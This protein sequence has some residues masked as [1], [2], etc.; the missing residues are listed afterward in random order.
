MNIRRSFG[1]VRSRVTALATVLV[2]VALCVAAVVIVLVSRNLMLSTADRGTSQRATE[3]ATTIQAEGLV[4][5]D[6]ALLDTDQYVD[7]IQIIGP[8]GEVIR[9]S[10]SGTVCPLGAPVRPSTETVEPDRTV[11]KSSGDFRTTFVGVVAPDGSMLTV[12]VGAAEAPLKR[13]VLVVTL[14]CVIVFPIIVLLIAFLTFHLVGRALRPVDD[15]RREVDEITAGRLDQRVVVPS[16]D[17]EIS[18]LA[19]TMNQML[20]RLE[21]ARSR[22]LKFVGDASHELNSPLTT[23]VGLTDLAASR[24][25]PIDSDTVRDVIAPEAERLQR[26]VA[27]LLLLARADENGIALMLSTVDLDELLFAEAARIRA[28]TGLTVDDRPVPIQV[29]GDAEKL[30][31]ALRNL[32]DN[33]IRHAETRIGLEIVDGGDHVT[34]AVS[35]DGPGVPVSDRNRITDR[36]VRLDDARTRDSGGSGLGLAIV[37]EIIRAHGGRLFV[38]EAPDGGARI[39]FDLPVDQPSSR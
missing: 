2:V 29:D 13:L 27:D 34:I 16:S 17:D 8:G 18:R 33:A 6:P 10:R 30:T 26:M 28:L 14:L 35:D 31:R 38:N 24:G 36:F 39:G 11:D 21:A 15:I 20:D 9:S 4:G 22:Q 12:A 1:P 23:I 25:E 19:A 5:V 37:D 3:I 7:V 32:V